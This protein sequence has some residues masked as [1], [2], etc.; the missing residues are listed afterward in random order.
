MF[1]RTQRPLPIDILVVEDEKPHQELLAEIFED[2]Q[3]YSV[4]FAN[5]GR[6]AIDLLLRHSFDAVLLDNNMPGMSG[7]EVLQHV[8]S[9]PNF[10][11]LPILMVT[12]MNSQFDL[13]RA[14]A[15]GADDFIA[16]PY[17]P[18]ELVARVHAAAER[19]WA[20]TQLDNAETILFALA[21]M[22]EARDPTT[23]RHCARLAHISL[24]FGRELGLDVDALAALRRGA[25]L[26][27]IGKLTV[28]DTILQKKG[29]LDADEW[30]V[31][32]RHPVIG[33]E[34]CQGLSTMRSVWPIIRHHH[35]AFDGSGYPDG[36]VGENI[37]F[38]ARIFR[39]ID[40]YDALRNARPYKARLPLD[41]VIAIL[42]DEASRNKCDPH[43]SPIFIQLA[44]HN[45]ELFNLST[46]ELDSGEPLYQSIV[47][48]GLLAGSRFE[49]QEDF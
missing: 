23:G 26:H 1:A 46:R 9:M 2:S 32:K 4:I 40:I 42:A 43:L 21:H 44:I 45:E 5:N 24:L 19:Q 29:P 48:R 8:R 13:S 16:K 30:E 31:M 28:P 41:K 20:I 37:P 47:R 39:I 12:G 7:L 34:L 11:W 38:L 25:I 15:A 22:V 49:P 10:K 33:A 3:K 6:E 36:L 27:D 17:S 18:I 35:E 14:M